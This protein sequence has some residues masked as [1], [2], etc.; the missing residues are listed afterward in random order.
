[1]DTSA[2]YKE[3]MIRDYIMKVNFKG[4]FSVKQIKEDLRRIIKETPGVEL[5]WKK[6]DIV[7]EINGTSKIVES[8]KSITIAITDGENYDGTSKVHT[9]TYFI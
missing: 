5:K 8:V 1:M 9:F 7:N 3:Q 4:N 6:D 2:S